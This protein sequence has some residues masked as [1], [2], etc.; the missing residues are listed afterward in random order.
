MPY[1]TAFLAAAHE[2]T[3]VLPTRRAR[4]ARVAPGVTRSGAVK[5]ATA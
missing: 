5:V 1:R 2:T 4:T 3:S